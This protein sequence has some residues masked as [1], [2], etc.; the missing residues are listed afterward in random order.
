MGARAISGLALLVRGVRHCSFDWFPDRFLAPRTIVAP[1]A[2]ANIT[3]ETSN[4]LIDNDC[5][6]RAGHKHPAISSRQYL[7]IFKTIEFWIIQTIEENK[8]GASIAHSS[9]ISCAVL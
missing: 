7:R 8:A 3:I 6:I 9:E 4:M 2:C 5:V 1:D